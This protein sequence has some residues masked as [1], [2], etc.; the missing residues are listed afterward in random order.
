MLEENTKVK[1]TPDWAGSARFKDWLE[2]TRDWCISRQRYWGIPMPIWVCDTCD[3]IKVIGDAQELGE[4]N[5]YQD[6]MD[7]HRPWIDGVTFPCECGAVMNRASDVLDVWFDSA[8]CS[9]AQLH[10]P[11]QKEEFERWW[12]M[13]WITEAQDQTRGW[14][15]SQLGASVIAFDRTP[16]EEVL[17]HGWSLDKDGRPMSKSAGN[18]VLPREVAIKFGVDSLRFYLLKA[19]APWEDI[20]F[21]MEGV[22]IANRSLN[23]LWNVY[24]FA[25]TYMEL[26]SYDPHEWS[27]ERIDPHL[28]EEDRWL[29]SRL[30]STVQVFNREFRVHNLHRACRELENFILEDLSRWYVRL[31]RDRTWSE[32]ITPEEKEFGNKNAAY[33]TLHRVLNIVVR[34][35]SPIVPH[36]SEEIFLNLNDN[37]ESL[38]LVQWYEAKP[39]VIDKELERKMGIIREV[40]ETLAS[41][42]QKAGIKLR[43]PLSGLV[44]ESINEDV[45]SALKEMKD[46]LLGQGNIKELEV[47]GAWSGLE[48]TVSPNFS[49]IGP[50]FKA[51]GKDVGEFIQS[52]D[53]DEILKM[54]EAGEAIY[55]EIP[56]TMEMLS[57]SDR[58]PD[59]FASGKFSSGMIYLDTRITPELEAEAYSRE[60]IRRIQ[61]M[62]KEQNFN[63]EDR[64]STT[65]EIKEELRKKIEDWLSYIGTETRSVD[66]GF[67]NVKGYTK[68][69]VIEEYIVKIG[70]QKI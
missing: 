18:V 62:R 12:P 56:V 25:T 53:P 10:Y 23:I 68:D 60:I 66:I 5:D 70:I 47:T 30:E 50:V 26:D 55:N 63:V 22:R 20:S 4:G 3:N 48:K 33:Y 57:I 46:I 54:V 1:W 52:K 32:N 37:K 69:W 59:G 21:S 27:E 11:K 44:V 43:W 49:G 40:V 24:Y 29:L 61:E 39:N 17:M 34:M 16:Y 42:R 15:Y 38:Y 2:N 7:L 31:V 13:H 14:F 19:S 9:W 45:V 28:R 58:V 65:L 64:I 36:I 6:G 35:L 8:V 51:D 41:M 67:G